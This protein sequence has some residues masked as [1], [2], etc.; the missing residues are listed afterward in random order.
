MLLFN[1]EVLRIR[2][3]EANHRDK[4]SF[5]RWGQKPPSS[6]RKA[7]TDSELADDPGMLLFYVIK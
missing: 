4:Q 7:F 6:S 1:K 3:L 2:K 5:M